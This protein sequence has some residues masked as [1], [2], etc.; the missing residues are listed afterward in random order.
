MCFFTKYFQK[1]KKFDSVNTILNS[2]PGL[3][4]NAKKRGFYLELIEILKMQHENAQEFNCW[5]IYNLVHCLI[6]TGQYSFA[7]KI[8]AEIKLEDVIEYDCKIGILRL[9]CEVM[10]QYEDT[11]TVLNYIEKEYNK[12]SNKDVL[13]A[14]NNQIQ[15]LM[16]RLYI[17]EKNYEKAQELCDSVINECKHLKPSNNSRRNKEYSIAVASTYLVQKKIYNNEIVTATEFEQIKERFKNLNDKRG[18]SW[19]LGIEGQSLIKDNH[20]KAYKSITES[21]NIRKS[22][23]ECSSE[24]LKW[25]KNIRIII[26]NDDLLTL[27]DA[28]EKRIKLYNRF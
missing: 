15:M 10:T 22:I 4:R 20:V 21:I 26:D 1:A 7:K 25:L 5:N 24:Y 12:H 19:I 14:M 9:M 11:S 3:L 17:E 18:Y 13:N 27:I 16:V 8:L 2:T 23:N 6:I 28:E